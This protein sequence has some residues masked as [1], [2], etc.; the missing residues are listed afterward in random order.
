VSWVDFHLRNHFI[1][2]YTLRNHLAKIQ[3][4]FGLSQGFLADIIK[5]FHASFWCA[6]N[7]LH[8][9]Y[10][11]QLKISSSEDRFDPLLWSP[12]RPI[13]LKPTLIATGPFFSHVRPRLSS[14]HENEVTFVIIY[15]LHDAALGYFFS[16]VGDS[17]RGPLKQWGKP[18][19]KPATKPKHVKPNHAGA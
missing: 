16:V 8:C 14:S 2:N 3:P 17:P 12:L 13:T 11:A 6:F 4:C 10:K 7:S 5:S 9:G 18:H 19:L 1:G 15:H